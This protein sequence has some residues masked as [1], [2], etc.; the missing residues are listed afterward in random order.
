[1]RC[2][3]CHDSAVDDGDFCWRCQIYV[4]KDCSEPLYAGGEHR[5]KD[6]RSKGKK[7]QPDEDWGLGLPEFNL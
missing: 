1:M 6:H 7:K 4:C 2:H 5:I 3:F